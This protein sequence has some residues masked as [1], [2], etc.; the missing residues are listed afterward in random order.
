MTITDKVNVGMIGATAAGVVWIFTTFASASDVKR[1]EYRLLKQEIREIR[2]E[3]KSLHES[4]PVR[5]YLEE[6]LQQAIDDLCMIAP[7]DRECK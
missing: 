7:E 1:I 5:K 6:D 4:D 2:R 3:L